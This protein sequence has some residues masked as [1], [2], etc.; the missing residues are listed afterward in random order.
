MIVCHPSDYSVIQ[1][2]KAMVTFGIDLDTPVLLDPKQPRGAIV[3][4]SLMTY[5][6]RMAERQEDVD[7]MIL[8][9]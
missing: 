2:T 3:A 7:V 6:A 9:V 8:R 1:V 5:M 4:V